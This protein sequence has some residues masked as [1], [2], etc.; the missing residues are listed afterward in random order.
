MGDIV[1]WDNLVLQHGRPPLSAVTRRR[2]QR[3]SCATESLYEMHP[4]FKV[5]V[6]AA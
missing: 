2:L 1:V 5:E 3:G 4:D 6:E